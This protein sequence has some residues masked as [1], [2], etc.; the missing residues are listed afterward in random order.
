[1]PK[2]SPHSSQPTSSP[3]EYPRA[4]GSVRLGY[5]T[6]VTTSPGRQRTAIQL[7]TEQLGFA[8]IAEAT[9]LG[10]SAH[11][12][13]PF[14]RPSLSSWL[15]RPDEYDAIVWAHVDRA[16]R[17][18]AHMSELIEW[19]QKRAKTLAVGTPGEHQPLV[20]T[21]QADGDAVRRCMNLAYA[22]EQETLAVSTRLAGT[23]E[24]LREQP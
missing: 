23:H 19:G 18:V 7:C 21:P 13:S 4:L 1:M 11:R 15:R 5:L 6:E 16:V 9:D 10:V 22:L 2:T 17:S 12:M 3:T 14:E 20:V 8:L 24:V